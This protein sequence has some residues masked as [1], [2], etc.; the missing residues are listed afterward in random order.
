M[1]REYVQR[2]KKA[3]EYQKK[4]VRALLPENVGGHLEVIENEVRAMLFDLA[5][6]MIRDVR[7]SELFRCDA[8]KAGGREEDK[9]DRSG[10]GVRKVDIS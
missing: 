5:A 9:K 4:A 2:V 3:M 8:V 7:E 10:A 1:T 6:N